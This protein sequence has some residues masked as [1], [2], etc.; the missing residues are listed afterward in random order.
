MPR[1][2]KAQAACSRLEPQPKLSPAIR[3]GEPLKVSLSNRLSGSVRSDSNAPRPSP[4]RLIVFSHLAGMITSV[5]MFL[6]PNGM[7]RPSMW[8]TGS[9]PLL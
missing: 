5:S 2:S 9:M 3:I 7:A 6:R 1:S 8:F 4:S